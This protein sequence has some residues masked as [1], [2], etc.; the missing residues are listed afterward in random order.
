MPALVTAYI[1]L[2]SAIVCEVVGTSFLM[3]SEQF[4][5][6]APT[7]I[8]AVLYVLSF[9]FLS[10]AIKTLPLGLAYAVWGGLGIVLIASIDVLVFKQTIDMAGIIG[11]GLI[12]VGVIVSNGLSS[13]VGH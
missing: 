2:T 8:M 5:R 7:L 9:Y 4:T 1:Y 6:P 12:V 3:K 10:Q 13:S 11:I